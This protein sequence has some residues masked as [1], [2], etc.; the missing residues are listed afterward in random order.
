MTSW[1]KL[2][3]TER[4]KREDYTPIVGCTRSVFE[5]QKLFHDGHGGGEGPDPV[6]FIMW[7]EKRVYFSKSYDEI[8]FSCDSL[9]RDYSTDEE[10]RHI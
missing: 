10:S 7:T 1:Y 9:P 4:D 8:Y 6:P 5:M 3:E 2:L